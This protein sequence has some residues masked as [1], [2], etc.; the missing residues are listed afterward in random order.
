MGKQLER[1]QMQKTASLA[2]YAAKYKRLTH[3]GVHA[4]VYS[5]PV[6]NLINTQMET[7]SAVFEAVQNDVR[8]KKSR[9]SIH[10]YGVMLV[11]PEI[12]AFITLNSCFAWDTR[13]DHSVRAYAEKIGS[14]VELQVNQD[15]AAK[16][17]SFI[18]ERSIF[19]GIKKK[20]LK[21]PGFTLEKWGKIYHIQLGAYMLNVFLS[22]SD[23]FTTK[24]IMIERKNNRFLI[25]TKKLNTY[26]NQAIDNSVA[27]SALYLPMIDI[28]LY[29]TDVNIKGGYYDKELQYC[30]IRNT[31]PEHLAMLS[32]IPMCMDALNHM[33]AVPYTINQS[34]LNLAID[35]TNTQ[36]RSLLDLGEAPREFSANYSKRSRDVI[37]TKTM[38][39]QQAKLKRNL[40]TITAAKQLV[41]EDVYFPWFMDWRGR[42]YPLASYLS[43]QGNDLSRALIQPKKGKPLTEEGYSHLGAYVARCYGLR[44]SHAECQ[45]WTKENY[46]AL[47]SINKNPGDNNS[48]EFAQQADKPMQFIRACQ[49][50]VNGCESTMMCNFF[51][52]LDATANV[53]QHFAAMTRDPA[54]AKLTNMTSLG[55]PEDIYSHMAM[56]LVEKGNQDYMMG[57]ELGMW[58]RHLNRDHI[59]MSLMTSLLN[60]SIRGNIMEII[61]G[62]IWQGDLPAPDAYFDYAK[63]LIHGMRE[64]AQDM[65]PLVYGAS[66]WLKDFAAMAGRKKQ[67]LE[68]DMPSG[69][70]IR[71]NS[72]NHERAKVGT[73]L[74]Q[75]RTILFD[76]PTQ[77]N[78]RSQ[79]TAFTANFQHSLDAAHMTLLINR[80]AAM[81]IDCYSVHDCIAVHPNDVDGALEAAK[82]TFLLLH[83]HLNYFDW[84]TKKTGI[85]KT[86]PKRGDWDILEVLGSEYFFH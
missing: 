85:N 10:G 66:K 45:Q 48:L 34:I 63:Y 74:G 38:L 56:A 50:F 16:K 46:E 35:I 11:E 36:H 57:N 30:M 9:V 43:P 65:W 53:F 62:Q 59:K 31:K 44:G 61:H 70:K 5:K 32:D 79:T 77:F 76:Q 68:W 28:P 23:L 12:L 22:Y 13:S 6:K 55:Y 51:I 27:F 71:S 81:S 41:D 42:Y 40:N 2:R 69:F 67:L 26:L 7:L 72:F 29:W 33:Q 84:L 78:P 52:Q 25:G 54:V 58:T 82:V 3:G 24:T 4:E 75:M 1:E 83:E 18:R 64:I 86:L 14:L 20:L 73:V 37:E 60:N 21:L 8:T 49:A 39:A 19:T 15:K 80:L 17:A 47:W